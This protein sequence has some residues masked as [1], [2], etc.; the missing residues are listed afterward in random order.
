M[1]DYTGG[2]KITIIMFNNMTLTWLKLNY[3][4]GNIF[5]LYSYGKLNNRGNVFHKITRKKY[6]Q[7]I[8]I[9]KLSILKQI[10]VR[11]KTQVLQYLP[12][13]HF[14]ITKKLRQRKTLIE[15]LDL[16]RVELLERITFTYQ[17]QVSE[18][19][20]YIYLRLHLLK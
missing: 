18:L 19:I 8:W 2:S 3:V 9:K 10:N 20:W 16:L 17:T 13:Q 14:P 4:R 12:P 5:K 15:K 7:T 1:T 11:W 6:A